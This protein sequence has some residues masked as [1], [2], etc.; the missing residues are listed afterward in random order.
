[1]IAASFD[2]S[3]L[4][5]RDDAFRLLTDALQVGVVL[6]EADTQ[7]I[8]YG[9]PMACE[10][11]GLTEDQLLGR[12]SF[13][14][15]WHFVDADGRPLEHDEYPAIRVAR[16]GEPVHDLI[17]GVFRPRTR[18]YAWGA[19]R[20]R[21]LFDATGTLRQ[22]LVSFSDITALRRAEQERLAALGEAER[23]RRA[24][25]EVP[26]YV[27]MKGRDR[28]YVYANAAVL[29]LFGVSATELRGSP[30][31]RFFPAATVAQL[32]DIDSRV[33]AGETTREEVVVT[34]PDG[35]T[36]HYLEIKSPLIEP[37]APERITGILG[38]SFDITD[39]KTL[40]RQ[41][42]QSQRLESIGRLA[43]GVAHDFNNMLSV[44][45]GRTEL[46]LSSLPPD[47]SLQ[48]DLH[49]I[50]HVATRS[51]RLTRQLLAFARRQTVA[52][53]LLDLDVELEAIRSILQ[54]LIGADVTLDWQH[55]PGLWPVWLDPT[56]LDQILTNLC[57]N[58]HDAIGA[59]QSASSANA[60]AHVVTIRAANVTVDRA[61][62]ASTADASEGDYVCL[63]VQDTGD[64]IAP[65]VLPR[66][67]EP[68]FTTKPD[69]EGTGLGL[70]TVFGTVRQAGGFVTVESRPGQGATFFA[71]LP[72]AASDAQR[73]SAA[74]D[75]GGGA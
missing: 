38:I 20:G 22:V 42:Q 66:I 18:D 56:Q 71:Y 37:F 48:E 1:M 41:L 6:H 67:F 19:V 5:F 21:P 4:P 14:P 65:E 25:D 29:Q 43:G 64:G 28:C 27:Y 68:F 10:L 63:S 34:A 58:A 40:E 16:S 46:A 30:D 33:L 45:L 11:L 74:V 53:R 69:G 52:P 57:V 31:S 59:A 73:P 9:N 8:L 35:T 12:S 17:V 75:T 7:R 26:A 39:R 13:D 61:F 72:R 23:F 24:L 3:T 54:R 55:P 70:A 49:E 47:S 36:R 50:R 62:S 44:I 2:G 32:H 15:E 51:A 60:R